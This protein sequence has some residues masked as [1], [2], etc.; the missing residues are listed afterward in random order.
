[1]SP[2]KMSNVHQKSLKTRFF[3]C[4]NNFQYPPVIITLLF[5]IIINVK[6]TYKHNRI[7]SHTPSHI[8]VAAVDEVVM[9]HASNHMLIHL[10]V[11]IHKSVCPLW[12]I[13][14]TFNWNVLLRSFFRHSWNR[15]R[16]RVDRECIGVSHMIY[17]ITDRRQT[18]QR[19][20]KNVNISSH[21]RILRDHP[22]LLV[23]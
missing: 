7:M 19:P 23:E 4:L 22:C 17:L 12:S 11:D 20:Q 5:I 9:L 10:V 1:M 15:Y 13:Y 21:R 18:F 6:E 16:H 3:F 14:Y 2:G 8:Q